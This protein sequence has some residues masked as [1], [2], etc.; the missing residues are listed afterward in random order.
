MN[1]QVDYLTGL[2]SKEVLACPIIND[3]GGVVDERGVINAAE[4]GSHIKGVVEIVNSKR[5]DR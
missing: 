2:T 1:G 3:L 4:K 5:S